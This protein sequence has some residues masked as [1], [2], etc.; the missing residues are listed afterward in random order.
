MSQRSWI[1]RILAFAAALILAL[2]A[3]AF[4]APPRVIPGELIIKY[5]SDAAPSARAN[6]LARIK[7]NRVREFRRFNMEHVRLRDMTTLLARPLR[8]V[9]CPGRS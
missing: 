3:L 1:P 6:Y 7:A 5:R 9:G 4:A 8:P 2:P